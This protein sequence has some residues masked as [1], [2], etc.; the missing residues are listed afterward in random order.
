MKES[1]AKVEELAQ[2]VARVRKA[3]VLAHYNPDGDAYGSSLA[4]TLA[5]RASGREAV[6][7]NESGALARFEFLPGFS[8][9]RDAIPEGSF[10]VVIACDCGDEKRVGDRFGPA[11]KG[12]A[13][14]INI[15][16]HCSNTLFG[17]TNFVVPQASS[18]C[19]LIFDLIRALEKLEGRT[20]LTKEI[21]TCLYVGI[22]TDT[23]SFKYSSTAPHTLRV[24]AEL[25]EAGVDPFGVAECL[26]GQT[27][28][29]SLQ[30]QTEA[31]SKMRVLLEGRVTVVE[32]TAEQFRRFNADSDDTE[33]LV[34]AARNIRGVIVS[35]FL[36]EEDGFWKGSLRSKDSRVDVSAVAALFGGGGHR[37]AAGFRWRKSRAEL[38]AALLPEV[39]KRLAEAGL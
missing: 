36:R 5:L 26:Y 27:T 13:P 21:A 22:S 4:L 18:T 15:D 3:L 25:V 6:C 11:L 30:L 35:V 9:L 19:E 17:E 33:G 24:A 29:R 37:A 39:E 7:I 1:L 20:L 34:E 10:D 16:H 23:G 14:V 32:V 28:L 2:R 8:E 38:D 12:R 31:L